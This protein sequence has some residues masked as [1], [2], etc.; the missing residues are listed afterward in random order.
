MAYFGVLGP[1]AIESPP[2][3]TALIAVNFT[4]TKQDFGDGWRAL[5]ENAVPMG[6]RP[7]DGPVRM[8]HAWLVAPHLA[9]A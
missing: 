2:G 5:I 7:E 1:L 9:A 8:V 6:E 4:A 3:H